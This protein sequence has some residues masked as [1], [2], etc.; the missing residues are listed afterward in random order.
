M[1]KRKHTPA[2]RPTNKRGK[3]KWDNWIPWSQRTLTFEEEQANQF[4]ACRALAAYRRFPFPL[5]IWM[6][7]HPRVSGNP[8]GA[9]SRRIH[10]YVFQAHVSVGEVTDLQ[11]HCITPIIYTLLTGRKCS[12]TTATKGVIIPLIG[13][14][15][16]VED[17]MTTEICALMD[18]DGSAGYGAVTKWLK[19]VYSAT[20]GY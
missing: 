13:P 2:H 16:D 12:H 8:E 17:W 5:Q 11:L 10:F 9:K 14:G 20:Q 3:P 4:N 1:P 6:T 19:P 7:D 15:I 18:W